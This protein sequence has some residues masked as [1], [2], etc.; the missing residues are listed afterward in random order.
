VD[1]QPL[2]SLVHMAVKDLLNAKAHGILLR[3]IGSRGIPNDGQDLCRRH[4]GSYPNSDKPDAFQATGHKGARLGVPDRGKQ[5]GIRISLGAT[6]ERV[7]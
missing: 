2:S 5:R 7:V 6:D 3:P 1:V 4:C